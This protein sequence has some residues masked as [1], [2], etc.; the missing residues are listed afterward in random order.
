MRTNSTSNSSA[1]VSMNGQKLEGVT[2][3]KNLGA[4]LCNDGTCI[5]EISTRLAAAMAAM[6]RLNRIRR[7][8]II[9]FTSKFKLYESLV[10]FPQALGFK[11]LDPF[12]NVSKHGLCFTAIEKEGGNNFS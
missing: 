11:S 2:N 4:T 5:A 12:P 6:A 9:S 1:D 10:N 3:F 7:S 8:E